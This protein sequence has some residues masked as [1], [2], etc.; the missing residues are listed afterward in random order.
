M[1]EKLYSPESN[2]TTSPLPAKHS[3]LRQE[4]NGAP[5]EGGAPENK[6][7]LAKKTSAERDRKLGSTAVA[8]AYR[9]IVNHYISF[10]VFCTHFYEFFWK[11]ISY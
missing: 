10:S 1:E 11:V 9:V 2:T 6:D 4:T 7:E 3:T 8:D 5:D